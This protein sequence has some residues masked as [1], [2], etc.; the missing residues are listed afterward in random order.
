MAITLN[1]TTGIA[2]V[3][4]SV[5]APSIRVT[6]GN[7]GISYGADFIKFSTGG[8]ERTAIT[9]TGYPRILQVVSTTKT[10]TFSVASTSYTDITGLSVAITPTASTSKVLVQATFNVS[11]DTTD[12]WS[13]FQ[14]VRGSTAIDIGGAASSR[15][16]G[17]VAHTQLTANGD[18][19]GLASLSLLFL[20]SP[21]STSATTYKIQG[22]CQSGV[23]LYLN[24]SRGD[25][26]DTY[27]LRTASSITVSEVAA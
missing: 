11:L 23:T 8:V 17:S 9:N 18:G 14:L 4:A 19:N 22:K 27:G 16:V 5:A 20:D 6:D 26:D 1:G 2:S 10:D 24:R 3:D 21:S 25:A 15:S 13:I 7:T 12:R